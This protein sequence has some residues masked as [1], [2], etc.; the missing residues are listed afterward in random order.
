MAVRT[1]SGEVKL[2]PCR[3]ARVSTLNHTST[4]LSQ[5]AWVGVKWKW[6][7]GWR[8]SHRSR[9]GLWVFRLSRMTWISLSGESATTWFMKMRN[10]PGGGRLPREGDPRHPGQP[11]HPQAEAGSV[12]RPPPPGPLPLH[13]HPRLLAQPGGGVGQCAYPRR[14]AGSQ[15]HL[16]GAG[17]HR[18]RGVR[19][20][21]QSDGGALPVAEAGGQEHTPEEEVR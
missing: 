7:W 12:A 17:A 3:A 5:E 9:F 1:C 13:S 15:L 18:H 11:E 14:P 10:E 20:R 16:S 19:G 4:W 2:A 6:T 8:A 21:L